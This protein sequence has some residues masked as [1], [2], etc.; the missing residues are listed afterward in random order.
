MYGIGTRRI[1]G[2]PPTVAA[3]VA[4]VD[5]TA[6]LNMFTILIPFLVSMTAFSHLAV[7][8]FRLPSDE[9]AGHAQ[10]IEQMPLTVVLGL[11][12]ITVAHTDLVLAT[13]DR[14]AGSAWV[15]LEEAMVRARAGRPDVARVVVAV[16]DPVPCEDIVDCLDACRHGGFEEVGLAAGVTDDLAG[17]VVDGV[18]DGVTGG[19]AAGGGAR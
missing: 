9:A 14:Q 19:T 10:T 3:G 11:E 18:A 16:D 12:R 13:V 1:G 15:A 6:V 8:A 17:G 4:E 5:V 2:R 7:Q